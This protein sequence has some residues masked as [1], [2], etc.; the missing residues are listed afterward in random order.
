M[1]LLRGNEYREKGK[2]EGDSKGRQQKIPRRNITHAVEAG[3]ENRTNR[4]KKSKKNGESK[5]ELKRTMA[6]GAS[7]GQLLVV[8]SIQT[9]ICHGK[10]CSTP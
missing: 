2:R 10:S 1:Q 7:I 5:K 4:E 9:I 6:S 8:L 3:R